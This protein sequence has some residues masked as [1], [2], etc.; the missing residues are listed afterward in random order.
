M[1]D[2]SLDELKE[3]LLTSNVLQLE[4][5]KQYLFVF[6]DARQEAIHHAMQML[7]TRGIHCIGMATYADEE[8]TIVEMPEGKA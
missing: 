6:K 7:R 5:G 2:L 1:S 8:L 4:E 3:M